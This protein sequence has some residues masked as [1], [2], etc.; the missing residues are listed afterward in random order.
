MLH[1]FSSVT[2]PSAGLRSKT[3]REV[4]KTRKMANQQ[5]RGGLNNPWSGVLHNVRHYFGSDFFLLWFSSILT[6]DGYEAGGGLP[7]T[8][9]VLKAAPV[10]GSLPQMITVSVAF[11]Q[12]QQGRGGRGDT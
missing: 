10:A 7:F 1:L 5:H 6:F 3:E 11:Y 2:H 9:L 8:C 4:R 12:M